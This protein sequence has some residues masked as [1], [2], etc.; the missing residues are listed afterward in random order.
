MSVAMQTNG[1]GD[2]LTLAATEPA[3]VRQRPAHKIYPDG[4]G[5]SLA[6]GTQRKAAGAELQRPT[7]QRRFRNERYSELSRQL[8]RP[9]F[10]TGIRQKRRFTGW[11]QGG[12]LHADWP[13]D[14]PR[15]HCW[16]WGSACRI[17]SRTGELETPHGTPVI[18]PHWR[19]GVR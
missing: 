9:D 7:L 18:A 10:V 2:I 11:P 13:D 15:C 3:P 5:G 14:L 19:H 6:K 4:T 16:R 1:S 17:Q 8:G 12:S